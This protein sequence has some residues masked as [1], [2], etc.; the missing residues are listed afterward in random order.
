MASTVFGSNLTDLSRAMDAQQGRRNEKALMAMQLLQAVGNQGVARSGQASA[1]RIASESAA[2][3]ATRLRNMLELGREQYGSN[4]RV[5]GLGHASTERIAGLERTSRAELAE[6]NAAIGRLPFSPAYLQHQLEMAR[7]GMKLDPYV[8]RDINR[9]NIEAQ[10]AND[11]ADALA[12]SANQ[13]IVNAETKRA[14]EMARWTP[15]KTDDDI[16]LEFETELANINTKL[17]PD[18]TFL[19]FS[20]LTN[21]YTARKRALIPIPRPG[22]NATSGAAPSVPGIPN[23]ALVNPPSYGTS[24]MSLDPG[25]APTGGAAVPVAHATAPPVGTSAFGV[26]SRSQFLGPGGGAAVPVGPLVPQYAATDYGPQSHRIAPAAAQQHIWYPD[27]EVRPQHIW[28]PDSELRPRP[29][30]PTSLV[31][32]TLAPPNSSGFTP[33]T[34]MRAQVPATTVV[35]D[36]RTAI[37]SGGGIQGVP[38]T[39][40]RYR[41]AIQAQMRASGGIQGV[42]DTMNRFLEYLGLRGVQQP[43]VDRTGWVDPSQYAIPPQ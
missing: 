10:Q 13:A 22:L 11:L 12:E 5:A 16:K 41:A 23:A 42:P 32:P 14:K 15:I 31:P 39:F 37:R 35:D 19:S 26:P 2:N 40:G 21:R 7:L 3:E 20:P 43:L 24:P 34:Q 25:V 18:R 29:V 6:V 27:A 30:I 4:E 8:E 36:M 1:E 33:N 28:Y 9:A 17:G 38:D